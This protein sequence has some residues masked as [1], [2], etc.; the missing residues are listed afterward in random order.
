MQPSEESFPDQLLR[1]ILSKTNAFQF[2][3]QHSIEN[4]T[5]IVF[6]YLL[7]L[8]SLRKS[9][10]DNGQQLLWPF[11]H[12]HFV[13]VDQLHLQPELS[14]TQGVPKMLL[15]ARLYNLKH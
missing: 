14:D 2:Y 5:I 8:D 7:Y 11:H 4:Y 3:F 9:L 15:C 1:I 12:E 10:S 6:Q 13:T